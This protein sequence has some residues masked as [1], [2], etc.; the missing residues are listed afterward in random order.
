MI[1]LF[2]VIVALADPEPVQPPELVIATGKPDVA[3]AATVNV[4]LYA[5]DD[6]AAVVTVIVW[7]PPVETVVELATCVAAL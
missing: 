2:M 5:A 3:V 4:E 7:L 1:P 6:G